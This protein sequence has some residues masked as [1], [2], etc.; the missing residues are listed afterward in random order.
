M[1]KETDNVMKQ[2][3][4]RRTSKISVFYCDLV[5]PNI[6]IAATTS[7]LLADSIQSTKETNLLYRLLKM[8]LRTISRHI[9]TC[10]MCY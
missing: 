4:N 3:K 8:C 5:S 9:A 2:E 1:M 7:N 10:H 6:A